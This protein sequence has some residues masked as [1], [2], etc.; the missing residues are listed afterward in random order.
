MLYG[1]FGEVWFGVMWFAVMCCAVL[2]CA[3]DVVCC[4]EVR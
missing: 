2:C 3:V 4:G 1:C